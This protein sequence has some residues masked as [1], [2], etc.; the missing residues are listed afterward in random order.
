MA[1]E[2]LEKIKKAEAASELRLN[3]A[4]QTADKR[5]VYKRQLQHRGQE[6]C[7]IAVNRDGV[8]HCHKDMGLVPEVFNH[9]TLGRLGEGQIAIGHV[10]Y[11]TTGNSNR[12]NAQPLVCLLYTSRCV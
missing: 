10:R 7:G 2:I 6:S 5:D 4:R 1:Q 8:I 3:Q 11:S 12:I 9:D